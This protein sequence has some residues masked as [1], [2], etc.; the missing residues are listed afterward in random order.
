MTLLEGG[1]RARD[2]EG[3]TDQ[4]LFL[5]PPSQEA[6][7]G[8]TLDDRTRANAELTLNTEAQASHLH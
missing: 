5:V 8:R 3:V 4:I 7:R 1:E 6:L 2:E